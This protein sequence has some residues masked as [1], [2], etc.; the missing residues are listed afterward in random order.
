MNPDFCVLTGIYPPDTGGPA[1]FAETFSSFRSRFNLRT[2]VITYTNSGSYKSASAT[3]TVYGTSRKLPLATRYLRTMFLLNKEINSGSVILANGCFLE[4]AILGFIR[5]FNYVVKIPGD[6]VWERAR[7]NSI[8]S[9]DIISFQRAKMPLKYKIFRML[10]S[11]S[12]KNAALVLVPSAQLRD[13]A[14]EWGAPES[15]VVI[16]HN[17]VTIPIEPIIPA[18]CEYDFATVSRLVPWKGIDQIIE[19]V[20]GQGYKLQ[21]IGDGPE[22]ERLEN[23]SIKYK[24]LV[25][26]HGN[27]SAGDVGQLLR[28]SKYFILNSSFEATSYALLEAMSLGL[29][30]VA[31]FGTGS[32]E[33][34]H[35]GVNG[36]LCG[37][38]ESLDLRQAVRMLATNPIK[39]EELGMEARKTVIEKFNLDVNYAQIMQRCFDAT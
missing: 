27:I 24:G 35:Q 30:P 38:P 7:N 18:K 31:N 12:V 15:L 26:F 25:H 39:S 19:N 3:G 32:Q 20:C 5:K 22:R 21:I 23:L 10:F 13:L 37:D 29:V 11:R 28:N 8:T 16:I 2:N 36:Y 1:K 34:I 9:Q 6:I 4:I 33:I 14:I 17:S